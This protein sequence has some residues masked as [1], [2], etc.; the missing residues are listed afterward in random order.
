MNIVD[1]GDELLKILASCLLLKS[2][3]LNNEIK[4]LSILHEFHDKI[5]LLLSFNNLIYLHNIRVMQLLQYFDFSTDSFNVLLV[6]NS[7]FF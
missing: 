3:M 1:T 2:L 5:E 4:K 6:F 7:R